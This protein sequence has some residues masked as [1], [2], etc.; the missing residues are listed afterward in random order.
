MPITLDKVKKS[1]NSAMDIK[2]LEDLLVLL[3]EKSFTRAAARRHVTQPA[4]SRRIR[5]LEEWLGV[6]IIDRSRKPIQVLPIGAAVEE[7]IRDLVNRLYS[8][9]SNLQANALHH[10]RVS[11]VVQHT[12]AISLFPTLIQQIKHLLPTTAYRVNPQNNDDCEAEFLKEAHLMLAYET[13]YRRFNFTNTVIER[14][15]LGVETLI[16]V[17][18]ANFLKGFDSSQSML[19]SHLP[20]LMYQQGGFL[21][22]ALTKTCLPAVLRDYQI[23]VICESAFSAS[24]KEMAL[25]NMGLTWLARGIVRKELKSGQLISL[26]E[27]LG[28][29]Q[30]EIVLLYRE[31]NRS[32]QARQVFELIKQHAGMEDWF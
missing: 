20:V 5:L 19:E 14:I 28:S 7:G 13:P 10:D 26:E 4:F 1:Y 16:P 12:L 8:M 23:D 29:A 24:L 17:V 3:E 9:R 31:D 21:S 6:D 2:W 11:F 27:E 15:H 25:A 32:I 30:L 18:S 22:E